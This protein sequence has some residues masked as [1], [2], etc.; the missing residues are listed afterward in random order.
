[1][2]HQLQYATTAD[3]FLTIWQQLITAV[4][5]LL[6]IEI[7]EQKDCSRRTWTDNRTHTRLLELALSSLP[8]GGVASMG[9]THTQDPSTTTNKKLQWASNLIEEPAFV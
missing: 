5:R 7:R 9:H 6:G 8:A 2:S 3:D 4:A 1:M